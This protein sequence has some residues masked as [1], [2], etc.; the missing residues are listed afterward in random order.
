MFVT[1]CYFF[2]KFY[3]KHELVSNKNGDLTEIT[4]P[5]ISQ[6]KNACFV[7]T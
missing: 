4:F 6:S 1:E 2:L 3:N 5:R 7:L